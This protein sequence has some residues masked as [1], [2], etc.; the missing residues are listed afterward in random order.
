[1]KIVFDHLK[2]TIQPHQRVYIRSTPYG[3]SNCSQYKHP[4]KEL[5]PPTGQPNQ[6][7]W[8]LFPSFDNIWKE[9]IEKEN[10]PRFTYFDISY[11][12]NLRGDAHSKP[13]VDCLHFCIGGGKYINI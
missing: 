11:M 13:D 1:M 4:M 6:Y 5:N 3:H 10:D 12:S 2:E 8:H 9:W 7:D